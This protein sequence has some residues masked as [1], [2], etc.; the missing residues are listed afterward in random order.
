MS[1]SESVK[2]AATTSASQLEGISAETKF[3]LLDLRDEEVYHR[4]HIKEAINFPAPNISRDKTFGQLLRFKNS[5]DKL[6]VVYMDDERQGT[7]YAKILFEKG[8][9]NIY[10]L[11]GGIEKFLENCYDLVEGEC[12]PAKP[13]P[14]ATAVSGMRKTASSK[15]MMST[16][17]SKFMGATKSS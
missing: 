1:H 14:A 7:Q 3:I 5:H 6:I 11:T 17:S 12:V 10:L 4:F 9:D 2:S 8:F 15:M 13:E 16:S